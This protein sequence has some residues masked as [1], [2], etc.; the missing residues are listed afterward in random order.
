MRLEENIHGFKKAEKLAKKNG[1]KIVKTIP[2]SASVNESFGDMGKQKFMSVLEDEL[3]LTNEDEIEE[4]VDGIDE[5][6]DLANDLMMKLLDGQSLDRTEQIQVA[7][8]LADQLQN[9]F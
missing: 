5:N 7:Y 2:A 8:F 6:W 1:W 4:W 9:H 3:G